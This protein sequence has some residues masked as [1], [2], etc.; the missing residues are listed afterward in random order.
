M[1][2]MYQLPDK[3][4][5]FEIFSTCDSVHTEKQKPKIDPR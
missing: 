2:K 5:A 3:Y 1:L 4:A